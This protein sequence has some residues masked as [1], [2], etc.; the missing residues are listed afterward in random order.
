M[1]ADR[2]AGRWMWCGAV[3]W[4]AMECATAS[5]KV[6]CK[7]KLAKR[8]THSQQTHTHTHTHA[9]IHTHTYARAH[10]HAHAHTQ[11]RT[12]A[13]THTQILYVCIERETHTH[14]RAR[15]SV[16]AGTGYFLGPL[17]IDRRWERWGWREGGGGA[18]RLSSHLALQSL[19]SAGKEQLYLKECVVSL[20]CV[21]VSIK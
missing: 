20:E 12:H 11:T 4:G 5:H 9:H 19:I 10:T 3:R 8:R 15:I 2:Q 17:V 16:C 1:H 14:A 6:M 13:R 21:H 7:E 18:N